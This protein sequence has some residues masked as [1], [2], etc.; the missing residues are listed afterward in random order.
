MMPP[1]TAVHVPPVIT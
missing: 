1:Y